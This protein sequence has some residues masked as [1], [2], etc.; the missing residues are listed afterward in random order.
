MHKQSDYCFVSTIVT[1]P[2]IEDELKSMAMQGN[3]HYQIYN[4]SLPG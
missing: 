3:F 1:L 4:C 2:V